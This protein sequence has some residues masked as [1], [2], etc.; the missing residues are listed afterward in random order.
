[1]SSSWDLPV[2]CD[3]LRKE[4]GK[5][6]ADAQP[7]AAFCG[8]Y[9]TSWTADVGVVADAEGPNSPDSP[10]SVTLAESLCAVGN[11]VIGDDFGGKGGYL[12]EK[13]A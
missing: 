2:D 7:S 12:N 10:K 11:G 5:V 4:E 8:V 3:M 9:E 1:M 13:H 6:A